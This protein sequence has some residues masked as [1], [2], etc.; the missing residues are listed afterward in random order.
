[1][2]DRFGARFERYR[3]GLAFHVPQHGG[4]RLETARERGAL[5]RLFFLQ[6]GERAPVERLGLIIES[7]LAVEVRQKV[8]AT[9]PPPDARV[10][11]A[12]LAPGS[13]ARIAPRL[14]CCG[15]GGDTGPRVRP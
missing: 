8:E 15:A 7:V 11:A 14:P 1:M 3:F 9:P 6:N 5:R 12:S 2:Q 10:P 4:E 13:G